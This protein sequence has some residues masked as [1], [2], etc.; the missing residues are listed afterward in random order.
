MERQKQAKER[1]V[2]VMSKMERQKQAKD[3]QQ[4]LKQIK[5]VTKKRLVHMFD[6]DA[7]AEGAQRGPQWMVSSGVIRFD[8]GPMHGVIQSEIEKREHIG[9]G[10]YRHPDPFVPNIHLSTKKRFLNDAMTA[11]QRTEIQKPGT[12]NI[13]PGYYRMHHQPDGYAY[14]PVKQPSVGMASKVDR[15][16]DIVNGH[17]GNPQVVTTEMQRNPATGPG[18]FYVPQYHLF[19]AE[20]GSV[21]E[22]NAPT[23][24][25]TDRFQISPTLREKNG[26][27]AKQLPLSEG[28]AWWHKDTWE[29]N[30]QPLATVPR[31]MGHSPLDVG[32]GLPFDAHEQGVQLVG[33]TQNPKMKC[34]LNRKTKGWQRK[35]VPSVTSKKRPAT[36]VTCNKSTASL[37]H[38]NSKVRNKATT[39]QPPAPTCQAGTPARVKALLMMQQKATPKHSRSSGRSQTAA[40]NVLRTPPPIGTPH[41]QHSTMQQSK[42][43]VPRCADH[44]YSRRVDRSSVPVSDGFMRDTARHTIQQA[45]PK[46]EDNRIPF[47]YLAAKDPETS[48]LW[49][50]QPSIITNTETLGPGM[51]FGSDKF[52]AGDPRQIE[53]ERIKQQKQWKEFKTGCE[54][55]N[56]QLD[57]KAQE[58][59]HQHH[60]KRVF[61]VSES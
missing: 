15:F 39:A 57:L 6:A 46:N 26:W 30:A 38:F 1:L 56:Q 24:P 23:V 34:A 25:K 13:G 35:T 12:E 50:Q 48:I 19:C 28:E 47:G 10:Q 8:L 45:T 36:T 49:T 22:V 16:A 59:I 27:A 52:G 42:S 44:I 18:Y 41:S 9:P 32:Y 54:E 55:H 29:R 4:K 37:H 2:P 3:Y 53:S 51:Y 20:D 61:T 11:D 5:C 17:G 21:K 31:M 33:H 58:L 14:G 60:G 43:Q 40:A 7:I